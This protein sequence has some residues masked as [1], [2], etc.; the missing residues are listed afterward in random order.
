MFE[1]FLK[2]HNITEKSI[3]IGVSG[4]S[5][6]LALVLM[7]NQELKPLGYKIIALTVNHHLRASAQ[8]EAEYV[9]QLM[10]K[11]DIEHH[12]LH[13]QGQKPLTGIEEAARKA[14]YNLIGQWCKKNNVKILMTAHH[15]YDQAE[16]FFMRLERGSGLDGLC[17]MNE[18][19]HTPD[20]IIARP[21]LNINPKI[22]K[23]YLIEKNINWIE[24]ESNYCTD[25]LRVKIRQ[26]LPKFEQQT[27]ISALK[28][29]QTMSR[30]Q[31]SKKHIDDEV[32][33]IIN[34]KFKNFYNMAFECNLTDFLGLDAELKYRIVGK[35][36]KL[37]GHTDYTPQ[38][39]KIF[40]LITKIQNTNFK[41]ATLN[42]CQIKHFNNKLWF[43]PEQ[44]DFIEYNTKIW[45]DYIKE[46]KYYKNK[47]IPYEIKKIIL[48]NSK[49]KMP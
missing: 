11:Y 29:V 34:N 30:L 32:S 46:N 49:N 37:V 19:L 12:I 43:L 26:F 41:S 36:L 38:A 45:K 4:G 24:D 9:A 47:K 16:T 21:L 8:N 18:V 1:T 35:L 7:A 17:G 5:D 44:L 42:K 28:I 40:N 13:W 15:L 20:F 33:N 14:R 6:S 2:K 25:L 48:I 27:G 39:D 23:N 10:K 22:M 3:C 31:S